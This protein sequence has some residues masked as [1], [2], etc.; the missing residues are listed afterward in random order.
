VTY[1]P[2]WENADDGRVVTTFDD[3][4]SSVFD[5]GAAGKDQCFRDAARTMGYGDQWQRYGAD[6]EA[7]HHFVAAALR[8]P[9]SGIIW[10][11]AHGIRRPAGWRREWPY[12][13]WDEEHLVNRLQ[14][15][16]MTGRKDDDYKVLNLVWGSR[17]PHLAAHLASWLCP[18]I[19][20]P[21]WDL[22][23]PLDPER[24]CHPIEND[25]D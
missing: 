23:G 13:G 18:W 19:A 25:E 11:T 5:V 12:V 8:W 2:Q 17:L 16:V 4:T 24:V 1:F 7:T 9:Y 6:H 14:C 3:G 10:A 22:P 20:Q 21:A 15:Y